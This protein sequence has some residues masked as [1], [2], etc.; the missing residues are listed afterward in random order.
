MFLTVTRLFYL[1]PVA[2]SFAVVTFESIANNDSDTSR[3]LLAV[4]NPNLNEVYTKKSE[5]HPNNPNI[6][7]HEQEFWSV[8]A[9]S[10]I[11]PGSIRGRFTPSVNIQVTCDFS[12]MSTLDSFVVYRADTKEGSYTEVGK[13]SLPLPYVRSVPRDIASEG[14]RDE[15]VVPLQE[16]FYKVDLRDKANNQRA[17][18]EPVSVYVIP[19]PPNPRAIW[20]KDGLRLEWDQLDLAGLPLITQP[21][22]LIIRQR[23]SLAAII[24]IIPWEQTYVSLKGL[25]TNAITSS[26]LYLS[27]TEL[28][29]HHEMWD[30]RTGYSTFLTS[31]SPAEF[32]KVEPANT[33]ST[34]HQNFKWG[35]AS[36]D[37]P[38]DTEFPHDQ[39]ILLRNRTNDG[40]WKLEKK[41][42]RAEFEE[43]KKIRKDLSLRINGTNILA[44]VPNQRLKV[45]DKNTL[46]LRSWNELPLLRGDPRP[47]EEKKRTYKNLAA[48]T[49][50]FYYNNKLSET[51]PAEDVE[52][53]CSTWLIATP[54][55]RPT[56]I[57]GKQSVLIR[58]DPV[59]VDEI[60]WLYPPKYV[61][62]R[63]EISKGGL[64]INSR[65]VAIKDATTTHFLDTEV[66]INTDYRYGISLINGGHRSRITVEDRPWLIVTYKP[67]QAVQPGSGT[68]N[69]KREHMNIVTPSP[70]NPPIDIDKLG[71]NREPA[72][73]SKD[74]K[75]KTIG[76]VPLR[77]SDQYPIDDSKPKRRT[78][79]YA[80]TA[81]EFYDKIETSISTM[82]E[83][84][85]V[86][87][88]KS[89]ELMSEIILQEASQND[90]TK[91]K[92]KNQLLP[93]DYLVG[94]DMRYI[95]GNICLRLWIYD[96][97]KNSFQYLP[98]TTIS[99]S[100]LDKSL[101]RSMQLLT[102]ALD[103]Q[104]SN[105]NSKNPVRNNKNNH[106]ASVAILPFDMLKS[107]GNDLIPSVLIEQL[108]I[109]CLSFTNQLRILDRGETTRILNEQ[110]LSRDGLISEKTQ[111][112]IGRLLGADYLVTGSYTLNTNE[113]L[114]TTNI[115]DV[116]S[117]AV[118]TLV[119]RQFSMEDLDRRLCALAGKIAE[120]LFTQPVQ[121]SENGEVLQKAWEKAFLQSNQL[122]N[123]AT[124][125]GTGEKE[126]L[127]KLATFHR[128]NR[129]TQ[130]E[131]D[132][133][134]LA[135][136]YNND[137]TIRIKLA[138]ALYK[139]GKPEEAQKQI[140]DILQWNQYADDRIAPQLIEYYKVASDQ[141]HDF[142]SLLIK[143]LVTRWQDKGYPHNYFLKGIE[144]CLE[145]PLT[146]KSDRLRLLRT[147]AD[148][149]YTS[150]YRFAQWALKRILEENLEPNPGDIY[151]QLAR[152]DAWMRQRYNHALQWF[153]K[154]HK[155]ETLN[156]GS[157]IEYAILLRLCDRGS[158][159]A[160]I[161]HEF[162][163]ET[164]STSQTKKK[165]PVW[166]I[167]KRIQYPSFLMDRRPYQKLENESSWNA[168]R[169]IVYFIESKA[170]IDVLGRFIKSSDRYIVC[171]GTHMR[172]LIKHCWIRYCLPHKKLKLF[173]QAR[174]SGTLDKRQS[175]LTSLHI[176]FGRMHRF[177]DALYFAKTA[178]EH[179]DLKLKNRIARIQ[180]ILTMSNSERCGHLIQSQ[181]GVDQN[182]LKILER[183]G[184]IKLESG[185]SIY[186]L[187]YQL[188]FRYIETQPRIVIPPLLD[189]EQTLIIWDRDEAIAI[190]TQT[191][192]IK[193][194]RTV[195]FYNK[196]PVVHEGNLH[197][198]DHQARTHFVESQT[199]KIIKTVLA[200]RNKE[201]ADKKQK[202]DSDMSARATY[203]KSSTQIE[204]PKCLDRPP[205]VEDLDDFA[206]IIRNGPA[207]W[208]E[209]TQRAL[210]KIK[211][212]EALELLVKLLNETSPEQL[213]GLHPRLVPESLVQNYPEHWL[214]LLWYQDKY[215]QSFIMERLIKL[216]GMS[217][218]RD[219]LTDCYLM[220]VKHPF[221]KETA[222]AALRRLQQLGPSD[223]AVRSLKFILRDAH[224]T[225][226]PNACTELLLRWDDRE[227]IEQTCVKLTSDIN[228]YV[229][230]STHLWRSC[231]YL[232]DDCLNK[233]FQSLEQISPESYCRDLAS[234]AYMGSKWALEE[235]VDLFFKSI[236]S[237]EEPSCKFYEN[238]VRIHRRF[239]NR[240]QWRNWWE[241]HRHKS[242]SD[243]YTENLFEL[244]H[245]G[246]VDYLVDRCYALDESL[247]ISLFE[248]AK[249]AGERGTEHL[250]LKNLFA[251]GN[252]TYANKKH[253]G[254]LYRHLFGNH[255]QDKTAY[256][257]WWEFDRRLIQKFTATN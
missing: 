148:E 235:F 195:H 17:I 155:A 161:L 132:A 62:R 89:N 54:D 65:V 167:E 166:E 18:S 142:A 172:Y 79:F 95:R 242:I 42:S 8:S 184:S 57:A 199:G 107:D 227:T 191:G 72:S 223:K 38:W 208:V 90:S 108:L 3:L 55:L 50:Y 249:L 28:I 70:M 64:R 25:Q 73:D 6:N 130:R 10:R 256:E 197:I 118:I 224:S 35:S 169:D 63:A 58:W 126:F 210:L 145:N 119:D 165:P 117:N 144:L 77:F 78:L 36:F 135:L 217:K 133:L 34:R 147:I 158:E 83:V 98:I 30:S 205:L 106:G 105:L 2:I 226:A 213:K 253:A 201:I 71:I 67:H 221:A 51:A 16:Y 180:K 202:R 75:P 190:D 162:G 22:W 112:K 154:A 66:Q 164:E 171:D 134:R 110:K 15:D 225:P 24:D 209:K 251:V 211:N 186:E 123:A 203:H 160:S 233:I 189:V 176:E 216:V 44:M 40:E 127:D 116:K 122:Y 255:L 150:D 198:S 84:T 41:V 20:V 146:S 59:V 232:G 46:E 230:R 125:V 143:I 19:P 222:F 81:R 257:M 104:L 13:R 179:S 32:L 115:I 14:Y 168:L 29:M 113:L 236:E 131:I 103:I 102:D 1:I 49:Q 193:W 254:L 124:A 26:K 156:I 80:D 220:L 27:Y 74:S 207:S 178:M 39:C 120:Q 187:I 177:H 138:I 175:Y 76:F 231:R 157:A 153:E 56:Y 137:P 52:N 149:F 250:A 7:R 12:M 152:I 200:N 173:N 88:M 109:S 151:I 159:A 37:V 85:L 141:P 97:V 204:R 243:L 183:Y 170:F 136:N 129:N 196:V 53:Y 47:F 82:P 245:S 194:E 61:I 128:V 87:R 114:I 248:M 252:L 60:E 101:P 96:V 241:L 31:Y 239:E 140:E 163:V 228:Q 215:T 192:Q 94:G 229:R 93:A 237:K 99:Y 33:Y 69:I 86:D 182:L 4:T 234:A 43:M 11:V 100:N 5:P 185:D 111:L 244:P 9:E 214:A 247:L 121:F 218:A 21:K 206:D 240:A 68:M 181:V 212:H 219:T 188:G 45:I 174:D 238:E 91:L 246:R 139:H 23:R 92:F 48:N